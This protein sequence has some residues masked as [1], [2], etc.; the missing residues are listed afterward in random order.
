MWLRSDSHSLM[1][2]LHEKWPLCHAYAEL[3]ASWIHAPGFFPSCNIIRKQQCD[4][5][6]SSFY[7]AALLF[8][9]IFV[10]GFCF[11]G[12]LV[13][14]LVW[15]WRVFLECSGFYLVLW[16]VI[17]ELKPQ[18]ICRLY[19]SFHGSE[20]FASWKNPSLKF[21]RLGTGW[22]FFP[23]KVYLSLFF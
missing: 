12:G 11:L 9:S 14:W 13:G 3:G 7:P 17:E 15:F 20:F 18:I 22:I 8:L 16:I 1:C 5:F 19:M 10:V 4:N 21:I 23:S 2:V 6:M